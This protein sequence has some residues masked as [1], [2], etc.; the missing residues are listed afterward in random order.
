[1]RRMCTL[2]DACDDNYTDKNTAHSYIEVYQA[3]FQPRQE[4]ARNVL[5][6]GVMN[7]GSI[8]MWKQFFPNAI[9]IGVDLSMQ[10]IMTDLS[11]PRISLVVADAYTHETT[12]MLGNRMFDIIIDDGPHTLES[13]QFVAAHYSTMLAPGGMLVIEDVQSM[14]WVEPIL[15]A[16]PEHMRKMVSVV[17]RRGVKGRYDDVLIVLDLASLPNQ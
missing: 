2:L 6:L 12:H 9:V 10:N 15:A 16:F 1:M 5:E 7:G 17:D 3:L 14:D 8:A 11:D 13:M 4:S